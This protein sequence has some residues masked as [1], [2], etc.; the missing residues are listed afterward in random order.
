MLDNF[1]SIFDITVAHIDEDDWTF[2]FHT[3]KAW[4]LAFGEKISR[5]KEI[6]TW[7]AKCTRM[8]L[9]AINYIANNYHSLN[10]AYILARAMESESR[11][12]CFETI[13]ALADLVSEN[14]N[15]RIR[16]VNT[17]FKNFQ[18][19]Y[20]THLY[21]DGPVIQPEVTVGK[22]DGIIG[23]VISKEALIGRNYY[24]YS[25][26]IIKSRQPFSIKLPDLNLDINRREP[27]IHKEETELVTMITGDYWVKRIRANDEAEQ[28]YVIAI[29]I[30]KDKAIQELK[31]MSE[32]VM[33]MGGGFFV[34]PG[35]EMD[36]YRSFDELNTIP[37]IVM[38]ELDLLIHERYLKKDMSFIGKRLLKSMIEENSN[39][40]RDTEYTYALKSPYRS[41]YTHMTVYTDEDGVIKDLSYTSYFSTGNSWSDMFSRPRVVKD[42]KDEAIEALLFII[43]HYTSTEYNTEYI[44]GYI[45]AEI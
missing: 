10:V 22:Y 45:G 27:N 2:D 14:T 35:V 15:S 1:S 44:E 33:R 19:Y 8:Q 9:S 5:R 18:M 36:A 41:A 26:G 42:R 37:E 25:D 43:D 38:A 28:N 20:G 23:K 7:L 32:S 30:D 3:N 17:D 40:G 11:Y 24:L 31:V 39:G 34:I 6:A 12:E 29:R 16:K 13:T 4:E 21:E